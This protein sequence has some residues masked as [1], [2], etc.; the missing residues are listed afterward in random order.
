MAMHLVIERE[1]SIRGLRLDIALSNEI[2]EVDAAD[3]GV[4][5]VHPVS[6]LLG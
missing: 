3:L 1:I 6:A 2:I 5:G 4:E